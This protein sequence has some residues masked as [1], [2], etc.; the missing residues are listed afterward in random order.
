MNNIIINPDTIIGE[1]LETFFS[2]KIY[3]EIIDTVKRKNF[4]ADENFRKKFNSFYRVRQK[5]Q[6]WYD[7]YYSLLEEQPQKNY[8]FEQLLRCMLEFG[9]LEVSFV[10]KLI[11]TVNPEKP[12]W[13]SK[14]MR[15]LGVYNEWEKVKEKYRKKNDDICIEKAVEIYNDLED[16]Y[17]KFIVSENGKKCIGKFD[18]LLPEYSSKVT[19]VKKIDFLL[20]G[21]N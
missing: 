10:S 6:E 18:E 2:L 4:I 9:T 12:I 17:L 16:R 21:K 15:N 11:A 8:T 19:N 5:K 14:V 20:W 3:T 13:D 1:C 7:K